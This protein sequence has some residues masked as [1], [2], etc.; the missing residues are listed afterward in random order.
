MFL[1]QRDIVDARDLA[2]KKY[3]KVIKKHER[4]VEGINE[5]MNTTVYAKRVKLDSCPENIYPLQILFRDIISW[6][7]SNGIMI[8]V[9]KNLKG[10]KKEFQHLVTSKVDAEHKV[11]W[12]ELWNST[13]TLCMSVKFL[14]MHIYDKTFDLWLHEP[15]FWSQVRISH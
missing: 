14:K 2:K 3:F 4:Y 8:Y 12:L 13:H 11:K 7:K 5:F 6:L 10:I 1:I 9:T 15:T